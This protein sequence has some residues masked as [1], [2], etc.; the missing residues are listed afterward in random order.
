M[1]QISKVL[2]ILMLCV[3]AN[4][5]NNLLI[6]SNAPRNSAI[7]KVEVSQQRPRHKQPVHK[8]LIMNDRDFQ[9]LYKTIKKKSFEK[10]QFELL[11]VGVLDNYFNC[12]QCMKIMSIYKFDK[13]KMKVLDIMANHIVDREN[14]HLILDS[15]RFDSDR[16]KAASKLGIREK[17]K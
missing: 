16:R 11:S 3:W 12:Q 13:D 1:K 10:D 9:Y 8:S 7:K 14:A 4:A 17:R 6:A 2:L 15:F 5:E